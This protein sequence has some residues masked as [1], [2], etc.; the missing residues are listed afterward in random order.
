MAELV[1]AHALGACPARDGGSSPLQ[2]T[3]DTLGFKPIIKIGEQ[4]YL[5]LSDRVRTKS[6]IA[7]FLFAKVSADYSASITAQGTAL[8]A[9]CNNL[10]LRPRR[11]GQALLGNQTALER[12]QNAANSAH[13]RNHVI[14]IVTVKD[15]R[16]I[17]AS[18]FAIADRL[19]LLNE[20][21]IDEILGQYSYFRQMQQQIGRFA[22]IE[23]REVAYDILD[24]YKRKLVA[25]F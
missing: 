18:D 15:V 22:E 8:A 25:F 23:Y 12:L 14:G 2:P 10:R 16:G 7:A 13:A 20:S 5:K 24:I 19:R 3:I 1:Y 11:L 4:H 17:V 6:E 9:A 21:D